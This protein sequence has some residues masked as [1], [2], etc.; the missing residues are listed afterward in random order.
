MA[1]PNVTAGAL[2]EICRLAAECKERPIVVVSW[3]GPSADNRRGPNGETIWTRE[4]TGRWDV[5]VTDLQL[6]NGVDVPTVNV[7]GWEFLLG[8]RDLQS[9]ST[10]TIDYADGQLVVREAI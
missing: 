5:H 2:Q 3:I 9:F 10:I 6:E 7:G 1:Q 4:S 8:G